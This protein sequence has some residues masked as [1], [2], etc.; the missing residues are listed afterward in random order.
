MGDEYEVLVSQEV[1][2]LLDDL[3]EK[4]ARIVRENLRKCSEPPPGVGQ[5]DKERITWRGEDVYRLHI[6]RTL[7]A[8]YDVEE[9]DEVVRVLRVMPIDDAHME[10]G[11]L[12]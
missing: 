10:Y 12:D 11:S 9:N 4:S 8:F 5:G 7:T 1:R 3:D 6:G 2:R